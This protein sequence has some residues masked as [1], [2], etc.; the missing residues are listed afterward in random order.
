LLSKE[1]DKNS[2]FSNYNLQNKNDVYFNKPNQIFKNKAADNI[3]I[4]IS[5]ID[6]LNSSIST[7]NNFDFFNQKSSHNKTIEEIRSELN[8]KKKANQKLLNEIYSKT[9]R[10]FEDENYENEEFSN[11]NFINS[12][13]LLGSKDNLKSF[14]EN[15]NEEDNKV[16]D[17][18]LMDEKKKKIAEFYRKNKNINFKKDMFD[19]NYMNNNKIKIFDDSANKYEEENYKGI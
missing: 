8:E 18:S 5:T 1:A 15:Y 9:K 13:K 7:K 3:D 17:Y 10:N 14:N 4:N 6:N 19:F 16:E 12:S 11:S 2:F